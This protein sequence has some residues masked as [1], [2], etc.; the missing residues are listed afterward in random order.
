MMALVDEAIMALGYAGFLAVIAG[1]FELVARHIHRRSQRA[2]TA[3]FTFHRELD[4]WKCPD[5][6]LLHREPVEPQ[7]KIV[8]YRAPAHHCNSCVFKFRCTSSSSGR[9]IEHRL[10]SWMESGIYRFHRAMSIA[11]LALAAML[12]G[13]ELLRNHHRQMKAVMVFA[14]SCVCL[15][16]VRLSR[17]LRQSARS[18]R[19]DGRPTTTIAA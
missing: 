10:E 8:R 19:P 13:V 18:D 17:G 2:T 4:V 3:G 11:L 7:L 5:G 16:G 1:V 15:I 12:L 14:L 6:R 9:V